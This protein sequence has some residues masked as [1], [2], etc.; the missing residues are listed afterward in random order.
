MKKTYIVL[1]FIAMVVAFIL[2]NTCPNRTMA[3]LIEQNN[4]KREL[5]EVQTKALDMADKVMD[6]NDLWDIDGSDDMSDYL[7]LREKVDSLWRTQC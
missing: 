7:E 4:V 5:I 1:L 3:T 6:N 2:G